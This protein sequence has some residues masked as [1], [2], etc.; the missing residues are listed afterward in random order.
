MLREIRGERPVEERLRD[1]DA[2]DRRRFRNVAVPEEL[3]QLALHVGGQAPPERMEDS[4]AC[5]AG[6]GPDEIARPPIRVVEQEPHLRKIERPLMQRAYI[7][8]LLAVHH[9]F[10]I[11]R[12]AFHRGSFRSPAASRSASSTLADHQPPAPFAT[13]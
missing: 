2:G 3:M 11:L 7:I 12:L 4:R 10:E 1:E 8:E 9:V 5:G 13:H 6:Y